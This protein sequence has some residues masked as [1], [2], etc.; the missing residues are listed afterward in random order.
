MRNKILEDFNDKIILSAIEKIDGAALAKALSKK[1]EKRMVEEFDSFLENEF[2]VA[3]WLEQELMDEDTSTGKA[4]KDG[5]RDIA[6]R[7]A[8]AI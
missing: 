4:F 7:M 8:K 5:M 1:L 3:Y 2:D 6:A